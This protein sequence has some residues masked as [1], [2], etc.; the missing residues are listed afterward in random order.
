[1]TAGNWG[2]E[3]AHGY[4]SSPRCDATDRVRTWGNQAGITHCQLCLVAEFEPRGRNSPPGDLTDLAR[5]TTPCPLSPPGQVGAA[6]EGNITDP[7]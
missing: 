6:G 3:D 7:L 1:M 2:G 5:Q 4:A